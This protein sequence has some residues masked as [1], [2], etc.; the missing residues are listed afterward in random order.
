MFTCSV[1]IDQVVRQSARCF[2]DQITAVLEQPLSLRYP[3][4]LCGDFNIHMDDP[5]DSVANRFHELLES[6]D[7]IKH[8]AQPIHTAGHILDFVSA[9]TNVGEMVSDHGLITFKLDFKRM[10]FDS[11]SVSFR[12]WK[13]L[14]LSPLKLIF[15][16]PGS[17]I[18]LTSQLMNLLIYTTPRC[19]S[20]LTNIARQPNAAASAV[21]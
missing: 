7:C 9:H 1:Y 20:Y 11:E 17:R 16:Y 8:I 10:T 21:Y 19:L 18:Y 3:V 14:S 15:E 4:V 5:D 6:F 2:F 13:M 12:Q